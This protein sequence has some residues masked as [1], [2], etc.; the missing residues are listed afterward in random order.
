VD[1][2]DHPV[3]K[4][5][6][7]QLQEW[8]A[9]ERQVFDLPLDPVGTPFQRRV[10]DALRDIEFGETATY[11]EIAEVATGDRG[12]ARAVG[13]AIGRNPLTIVVPC[14]RVIGTDGSLTGFAGG[15]DVKRK[16]LDHEAGTTALPF[17]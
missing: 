2:D 7:T 17:S 6:A 4:A 9:G 3:A 8:F 1:D 16:L 11:A 13:A 10:W 14:H 5:G 12:R 15:L